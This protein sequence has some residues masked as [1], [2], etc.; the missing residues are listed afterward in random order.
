MSAP[1]PSESYQPTPEEISEYTAAFNHFDK[2]L[3]IPLYQWL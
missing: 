2:S 1:V 3:V